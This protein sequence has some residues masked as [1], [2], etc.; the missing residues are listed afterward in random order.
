MAVKQA[1]RDART[2][3]AKAHNGERFVR[4]GILVELLAIIE[5]QRKTIRRYRQQ[6]KYSPTII[7]AAERS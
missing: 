3:I 7:K 4:V 1:V 2:I 6:L 5:R